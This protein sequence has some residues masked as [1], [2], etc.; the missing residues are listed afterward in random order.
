MTGHDIIK[1]E[2]LSN[3][4][5]I[6]DLLLNI[7]ILIITATDDMANILGKMKHEKQL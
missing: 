1:S 2:I 7:K 3:L 6:P 5:K 4:Q